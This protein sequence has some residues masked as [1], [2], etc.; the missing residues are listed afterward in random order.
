LIGA[1][2]YLENLTAENAEIWYRNY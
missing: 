1:I 2:P